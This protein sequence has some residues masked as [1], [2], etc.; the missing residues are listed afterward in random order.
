V[1]KRGGPN[2]PPGA[3]GEEAGEVRVWAAS[4][5]KQVGKPLP[6]PKEVTA[7]DFAPDG[8]TLLTGCGDGTARVWEVARGKV[9]REFKAGGQGVTLTQVLFSPNGRTVLTTADGPERGR[10]ARLWDRLTGKPIRAALPRVNVAVFSPGGGFLLTGSGEPDKTRGEARLWSAT[11]GQPVGLPLFH[12]GMVHL[13]AFS[14]DG[15]TALT[16]STDGTVRLW[17]VATTR[18]LGS[19]FHHPDL[20]ALAFGP[21]GKSVLALGPGALRTWRVPGPV[22]GSGARIRVWA[23]HVTGIRLDLAG[24]THWLTTPEWEKCRG[25]YFSS[26]APVCHEILLTSP[27]QE[28]RPRLTT[29]P[30]VAPE[31]E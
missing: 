8:R 28:R 23:E 19:P 31:G 3:G 12:P 24:G 30:G 26:G 20:R 13:A 7:I 5:Q 25:D 11:T 1:V 15:S 22:T 10:T 29:A 17:D 2:A 14:P 6:H 18:P 21:G 9:V 4:T 27:V 16:G